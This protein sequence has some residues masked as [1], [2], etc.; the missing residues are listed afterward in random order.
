MQST[1]QDAPLQIAQ[2]LRHGSNVHGDAEVVTW[3]GDGSRRRTYAEVGR[4]C[5][6]LAH[7]LR[8]LGVD[9]AIEAVGVPSTFTTCVEAVRPGGHVAIGFVLLSSMERKPPCLVREG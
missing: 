7:A 9:V 6:Q 2:I 8:G 1:M 4:R 3:T 5:A